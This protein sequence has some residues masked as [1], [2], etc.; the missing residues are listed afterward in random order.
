MDYSLNNYRAKKFGAFFFLTT[1]HG[2]HCILS[3]DEFKKLKQNDIDE[4]LYKKLQTLRNHGI[5]RDQNLLSLNPG[6]WYYEMINLGF[7]YR[8]TDLQA[9]LGISQL[10]KIDTFIKRRRGII[11]QYNLAFAEIE[12]ITTPF[13]QPG[14][15]SA[16]HLYVLQID[17]QQINKSRTQVFEELKSKNIGTQVHYIPVHTQP[18]Y[19]NKFGYNWGDCPIAEKY[20]QHALSIPLYPKMSD[21]DVKHVIESIRDL[22]SE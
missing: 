3:N 21:F 15:E 9:A 6:P 8:I 20:Y 18:Y 16:F 14:L 22:E 1:D 7:N 17:F 5:T 11:K 4:Q 13:E 19:R 10:R 12:W 2:S